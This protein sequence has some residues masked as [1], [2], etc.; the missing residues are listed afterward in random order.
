MPKYTLKTVVENID[1]VPETYRD[2]YTQNEMD[3]K[4]YLSEVEVDDGAELRGALENE[5]KSHKETKKQIEK[6]KGLDP[7]LAREA[8]KQAQ[9]TEEQKLQAEGKFEQLRQ[10]WQEQQ[11]K[12][13]SERDG[14][15]TGLEKELR[16][17]ML[18]DKLRAEALKAGVFPEDLNDVLKITSDRFDLREGK[19]VV[20]DDDG[21]PT[22]STPETFFG[23]TFKEQR[24]KFYAA[25]GSG[26]SGAPAGSA[27]SG[28]GGSRT[29]A[30]AAFDRMNPVQQAAFCRDGG[31]VTD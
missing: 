12:E 1:D 3:R 4:F 13:L 16:Q 28:S 18:T 15:I 14:K 20:L 7:D 10:K 29:I 23:Q 8:L 26:G 24:P 11:K 30:R 6:F 27:G 17:F 25:S 22:A 2:K 19:I 9:D 21:D 5:R 31:N